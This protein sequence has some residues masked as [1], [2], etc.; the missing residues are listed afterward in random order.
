MKTIAIFDLEATC[1][2]DSHTT[3]S[4]KDSEII[5][6]GAIK[7]NKETGDITDIFQT[8]V[9][10]HFHP[11]LSEYCINLTS[12]KQKDIFIADSVEVALHK[13]NQW[14]GDDNEYIMSWGYYDKNLIMKEFTYKNFNID[15]LRNKLNNKHLNMKKQFSNCFNLKDCGVFKALKFLNL[16]FDGIQHRA[17]DDVKNMAIIYKHVKDDFFKKVYEHN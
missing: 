4:R 13:F 6:I 1:W 15:S 14:L 11:I 12:I 8:F 2:E 16:K 9:R 10:P 17:I 3:L 7:L 5:E